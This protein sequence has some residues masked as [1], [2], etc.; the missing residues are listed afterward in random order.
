MIKDEALGFAV[1]CA[2]NEEAC[3]SYIFY[4]PIS[5]LAAKNGLSPDLILGH[6]MAHEIGHTLLGPNA[7]DLYGIM[8]ASLP[9]TD[10]G[11]MLYFTSTQ[12]RHLRT[13]LL[14]R[15]R[16]TNRYERQPQT[17]DKS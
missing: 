10:I 7:H 12:S 16:A 8:Q 3:L 14:A 15:K 2:K 13:E 4:S 1:P 11:R 6:V 9:L 17:Q 5:T